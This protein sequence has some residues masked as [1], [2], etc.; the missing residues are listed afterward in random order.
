M[1]RAATLFGT[2]VISPLHKNQTCSVSEQ[3]HQ[4]RAVCYPLPGRPSDHQHPWRRSRQRDGQECET[5]CR[6]PSHGS[7]WSSPSKYAQETDS[8]DL[9]AADSSWRTLDIVQAYT[10]RWL[11]EV[12]L[13]DWQGHEGWGQ[14]TKQPDEEGSSRGLI[15]SLRLD[16][17][18]LLHPHQ[19]AGLE[20][21]L[22]AYTVGSRQQ[23]TQVE[24]LLAFIRDSDPDRQPAGAAQPPEPGWGKRSFN[25]PLRRNT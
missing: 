4:P 12:F 16:H 21:K 14:L 11:V 5:L 18:L 25:S 9:V 3:A 7:G 23:R 15:L 2:Q 10:L 8:R 22:P 1:E 20:H 17:G 6:R 24:C 13:E 19:R